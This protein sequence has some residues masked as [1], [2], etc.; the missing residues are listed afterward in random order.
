M[1][2]AWMMSRGQMIY[3]DFFEHHHPLFY[4][5]LSPI[6]GSLP[7]SSSSLVT[8]RLLNLAL[9]VLTIV[10]CVVIASRLF[11]LFAGLCGAVLLA[12]APIYIAKA[13]EIRPDNLQAA[14]G[15]IGLALLMLGFDQRQR[16]AF[17]ASGVAFGL[18]FLAL[19]KSVFLLGAV[20]CVVV[21]RFI[22]RRVTAREVLSLAC[23]FATPV[24][25]AVAW[26][27]YYDSLKTFWLL[28]YTLNLKQTYV[29]SVAKVVRYT[30]EVY[31]TL[32]ASIGHSSL[33]WGFFAIGLCQMCSGRGELD[34]S[35][36]RLRRE[37][38]FIAVVL[39]A[40]IL[41]LNKYYLQYY[42]PAMPFVAMIAG[43][44]MIEIVRTRALAATTILGALAVGV[45]L[46]TADVYRK[47]SI[48]RNLARVER[49]LALTSPEDTVIDVQ[50]SFNVFRPSANYMWFISFDRGVLRAL[51]AVTGFRYDILASIVEKKP[52]IIT[53][54]ALPPNTWPN[55]ARVSNYKPL[56]GMEDI[57]AKDVP[58]SEQ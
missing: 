35:R 27:A 19:Q 31:S 43:G 56:I 2:A 20:G 17:V 57:L 55:D 32:G 30:P 40:W 38:A 46:T 42:L 14:C 54:T 6:V 24:I 3:R 34:G 48:A 25:P 50:S 1:H 5:I 7:E 23:G 41:V 39:V 22:H 16:L 53:V 4:L 29:A 15:L 33:L 9:P 12:T 52:A 49:V 28:C 13:V 36:L 10:C 18:M 44:G 58:G 26:L 47:N 45:W 11:S 51:E 21:L 8:L 37:I